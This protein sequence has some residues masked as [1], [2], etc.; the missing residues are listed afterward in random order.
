MTIIVKPP[1]YDYRELSISRYTITLI[2]CPPLNNTAIYYM[3]PLNIH[4]D[5][6]YINIDIS[7]LLDITI[8][9]CILQLLGA[10][11]SDV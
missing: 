11:L 7:F 8:I 9:E 1:R 10:R 6:I 5:T 2:Y 3:Y 4:T